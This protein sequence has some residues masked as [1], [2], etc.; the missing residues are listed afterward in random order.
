M[1]T[2]AAEKKTEISKEHESKELNYEINLMLKNYRYFMASELGLGLELEYDWREEI[3]R[4][5][6]LA[7]Y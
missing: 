3:D 7:K 6:K 4:I 5:I 1:K 2:K